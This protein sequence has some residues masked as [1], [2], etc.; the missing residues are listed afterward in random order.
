MLNVN[1]GV[2]REKIKLI[3]VIE[4]ELDVAG[5]YF[6]NDGGDDFTYNINAGFDDL[7][8]GRIFEKKWAKITYVETE[9]F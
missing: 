4:D 3:K 8:Q 7:I 1:I 6:D 2:P 5:V 9:L